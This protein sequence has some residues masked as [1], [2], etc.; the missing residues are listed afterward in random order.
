MLSMF[1]E[2]H[3]RLMIFLSTRIVIEFS[4]E[5]HKPQTTIK[6]MNFYSKYIALR[7][8]F[9]VPIAYCFPWKEGHRRK[10]AFGATKN[11]HR[12]AGGDLLTPKGETM[13]GGEQR[14][15]LHSF[16]ATFFPVSRA[17]RLHGLLLFMNYFRPLFVCVSRQK[18]LCSNPGDL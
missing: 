15:F 2:N 17:K 3:S 14:S 4:G 10:E 11:Y 8:F 1:P 13:I 9:R 7:I 5:P 16:L 18:C 6:L 12:S